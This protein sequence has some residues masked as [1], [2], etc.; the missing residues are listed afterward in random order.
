VA[1]GD[2][3]RADGGTQQREAQV[4]VRLPRG[5]FRLPEA[6]ARFAARLGELGHGVAAVF[7][8]EMEAGRG[9][10]WLAV[11]FA[12]GI[13]VYF[14]LPD[15]PSAIAVGGLAFALAAA[16]WLSRRRVAL[17]RTLLALTIV[18]V[19]ATTAK[20]RTDAVA[21]PILHHEMTA[22]VTGWVEGP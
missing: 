21:A 13:L 3:G 8:L 18:A 6:L 11:C 19:G 9:F 5:P 7:E 16:S 10:L 2:D 14:V 17:F 22:T 15:E 1:S 20:L 12:G 4:R